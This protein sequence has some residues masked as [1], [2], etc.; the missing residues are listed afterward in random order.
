MPTPKA[1]YA[2]L[3]KVLICI[4]TQKQK[5]AEKIIHI[6]VIDKNIIEM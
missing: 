5:Y 3:I 1:Q 4:N 2:N 6:R